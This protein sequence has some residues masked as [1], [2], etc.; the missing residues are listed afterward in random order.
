M[1]KYLKLFGLYY[2]YFIIISLISVLIY[3][4]Q[5]AELATAVLWLNIFYVLSGSLLVLFIPKLL[6]L[7][8]S[9]FWK[10]IFFV[11]TVLLQLNLVVFFLDGKLWLSYTLVS[12]LLNGEKLH[13]MNNLASHIAVVVAFFLAVMTVSLFKN[14]DNATSHRI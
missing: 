1:K 5:K 14:S 3:D 8:E 9:N 2:G 4:G 7:V 13:E 10:N 6:S 12:D 11:V